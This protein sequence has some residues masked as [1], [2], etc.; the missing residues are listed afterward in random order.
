VRRTY[1]GD[2]YA[3][4]M[5]PAYIE[6]QQLQE[7]C[8]SDIFKVIGGLD[9]MRKNTQEYV[10]FKASCKRYDIPYDEI[11]AAELESK[12][13]MQFDSRHVGIYQKDSV[14]VLHVRW[15]SGSCPSDCCC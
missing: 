12:Y 10:L 1:T 6:W 11:S 13:G 14:S 15:L 2:V 4:L 5:V 8:G 7:A 9:V 3:K